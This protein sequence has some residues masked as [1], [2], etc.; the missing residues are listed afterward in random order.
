M[1]NRKLLLSEILLNKEI[2]G[3]YLYCV[4]AQ[5]IK[6]YHHTNHITNIYIV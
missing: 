6:R 4:I 3:E 5:N 2:L 1:T